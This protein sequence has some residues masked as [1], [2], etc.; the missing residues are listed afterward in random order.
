MLHCLLR[1]LP[2]RIAA[3]GAVTTATVPHLHPGSRPC[4]ASVRDT[5][6]RFP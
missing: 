3:H 2:P 4:P 1:H 5:R 6:K